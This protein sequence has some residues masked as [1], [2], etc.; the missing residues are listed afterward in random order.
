M[1]RYTLEGEGNVAIHPDGG[2]VWI[3]DHISELNKLE[4]RLSKAEYAI[5]SCLQYANGREVEWGDRAVN[6]LNFLHQYQENDPNITSQ[7]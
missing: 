4:E 6:A 7:P 1:N 3:Y 2:W 5:R